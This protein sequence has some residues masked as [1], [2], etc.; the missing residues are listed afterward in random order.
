MVKVEFIQQEVWKLESIKRNVV[1][2]D[3]RLDDNCWRHQLPD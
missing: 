3:I 1:V 2:D